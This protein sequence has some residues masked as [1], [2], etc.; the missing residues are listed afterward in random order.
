[1]GVLQLTAT[2]TQPFANRCLAVQPHLANLTQ[3][4]TIMVVSVSQGQETATGQG[5]SPL[6]IFLGTVLC[7]NFFFLI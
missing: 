2:H 1:M 5:E 3:L 4:H 6:Q 7:F